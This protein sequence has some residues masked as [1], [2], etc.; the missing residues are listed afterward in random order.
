MI[1]RATME[2]AERLIARLRAARVTAGTAESLTG[3]LIAATLTAVPGASEV[4][5]RG[6]VVYS[7]E[8]KQAL[9]GVPRGLLEAEGAVSEAVARAMVE[10]LLARSE[11]RIELAVAVTGVAGPGSSEGKPAG[12]VHLAVGRR[13]TGTVTHRMRDYGEVGR[14]AVRLATVG[15]ALALLDAAL[16]GD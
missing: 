10:G 4:I 13:S 3:G 2:Q 16:G 5:D 9:L 7:W 6:V 11:G 1:D 8:A 15:D 12:R 14:A